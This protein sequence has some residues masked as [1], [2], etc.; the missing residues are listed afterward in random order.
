MAWAGFDCKNG[1]SMA[2]C[3]VLPK[4]SAVRKLLHQCFSNVVI[5]R[6]VHFNSQ[7]SLAGWEQSWEL[8]ST[9]LKIAKFEKLGC[10]MMSEEGLESQ[11]ELGDS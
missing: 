11:Q 8:T 3:I 9:P 10:C 2:E 5:L 4:D 7:N 1:E 6:R